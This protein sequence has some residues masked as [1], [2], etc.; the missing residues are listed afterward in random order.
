[1]LR[2]TLFI[3]FALLF[4]HLCE[5]QRLATRIDDDGHTIVITGPNGF[6]GTS[7]LPSD[8]TTSGY[9]FRTSAKAQTTTSASSAVATSFNSIN[10]DAKW[11]NSTDSDNSTDSASQSFDESTSTTATATNTINVIGAASAKSTTASFAQSSASSA[12]ASQSESAGI[13]LAVQ[14]HTSALITAMV[15]MSVVCMSTS[16]VI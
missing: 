12:S 10:K 13:K 4:A 3:L 7:A 8:W 6:Q 5:G 9:T 1:M 11:V 15:V 16:L 14:S 2:H